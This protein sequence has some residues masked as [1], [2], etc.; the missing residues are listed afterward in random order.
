M[1][2]FNVKT[3]NSISHLGLEKIKHVGLSIDS[4]KNANAILLRSH[5]L[6]IDEIKESVHGIFRAGAG[7]N[8]IPIDYC[9]SKGIAVFN[10]PGAN[11]NAV[12]ELVILSILIS[13]RNIFRAK[14][15]LLKIGDL[16]TDQFK[17]EVENLK[18]EF[19]GTEIKG[20]T[21]GIIGLG[22][23]GSLVA[24]SC[25]S[26]GMNVIG[27][28]PVI[29]IDSAWKLS[30]AIVRASS[31]EQLVELSDFI[32]LHLPLNS[33]TKNIFNANLFSKINKDAVLLNFARQEIVDEKVLDTYLKSEKLKYYVTDFP[34]PEFLSLDNV[35]S[36]PHL[37]A[38]TSSAEENC[39]IMSGEQI[40]KFLL[41]G[42][43]FN[44]VNFPDTTLKRE[45]S[46]RLTVVN[47]NT[48]NM[49]GQITSVLANYGINIHNMINKSKGDLAYNILDLDSPINDQVLNSLININ[50]ITKVRYIPNE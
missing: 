9:T 39:A 5:K 44:S 26:L 41:D 24:E 32:S 47:K 7:T 25:I 28:D 38:S 2:K 21:I 8:N 11:A 50:G 42:E 22:K 43:I 29:S 12:K 31:P 36:F 13:S 30:S 1:D 10:T 17:V 16:P 14:N 6:S 3:Y 34:S 33:S 35:I 23:I 4:D 37:G 19:V 27:Y 15:S 46:Y 40:I 48:P 20:R 18:K 45:S 49:V